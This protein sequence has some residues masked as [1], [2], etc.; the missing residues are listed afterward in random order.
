MKNLALYNAEQTLRL[1]GTVIDTDRSHL[2]T[3]TPTPVTVPNNIEPEKTDPEPSNP[4]LDAFFQNSDS[5]SMTSES[6]ALLDEM[7]SS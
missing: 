5:N 4:E 2:F 7:V 1:T 6:Q 3:P